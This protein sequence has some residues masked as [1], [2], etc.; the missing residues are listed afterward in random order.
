[1]QDAR[2]R[3]TGVQGVLGVR[4]KDKVQGTRDSSRCPRCV[5][6]KKKTQNEGI[7]FKTII[8]CTYILVKA[9][10]VQ[11]V[12]SVSQKKGRDLITKLQK[13]QQNLH[14]HTPFF[15]KP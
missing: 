13:N 15:G 9:M 4:R 2:D 3:A 5:K 11:G 7:E 6:C 14:P 12:L 10:H 1:M 8:T